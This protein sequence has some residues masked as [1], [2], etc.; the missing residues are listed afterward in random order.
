[1]VR[2]AQ[3]LPHQEDPQPVDRR[4]W[5]GGEF[6][7]S[8]LALSESALFGLALSEFALSEFALSKFTP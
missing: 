5:W 6:G 3:P 1:M 4:A 7:L 2:R 8:E